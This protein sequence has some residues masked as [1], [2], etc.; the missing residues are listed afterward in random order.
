MIL[1]ISEGRPIQ[2]V[3]NQILKTESL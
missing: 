1:K 2:E 3:N